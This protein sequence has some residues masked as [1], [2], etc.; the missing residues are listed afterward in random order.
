MYQNETRKVCLLAILQQN[1]Q[2][3]IVQH[4]QKINQPENI[5]K[6]MFSKQK[7]FPFNGFL[8]NRFCLQLVVLLEKAL[9]LLENMTPGKAAAESWMFG[10]SNS[11]LR[12]SQLYMILFMS[13]S[14]KPQKTKQFFRVYLI[15]C[16]FFH[17]ISW[18]DLLLPKKS[19]P[20][21]TK[22][23]CSRFRAIA[24]GNYPWK[25]VTTTWP[26]HLCWK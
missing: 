15:I 2:N 16:C 5:R 7:S 6:P 18:F 1:Q 11:W 19:A 12:R 21:V 17:S 10:W 14:S 20:I 3:L 25:L 22:H 13:Q 24:S 4:Q 26:N 23:E 9:Q 8:E